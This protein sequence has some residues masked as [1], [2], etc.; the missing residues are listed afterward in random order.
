MTQT[1]FI[2]PTLDGVSASKVFLPQILPTP[3]SLYQYL[4]QQFS[5]IAAN[6]WQQRFN[7]RLIYDALGNILS[8]NSPKIENSHVF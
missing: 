2:P 7:S 4:C 1:E 6:E 8:C 5:H 3:E